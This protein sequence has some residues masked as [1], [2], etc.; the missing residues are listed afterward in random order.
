MKTPQ[1]RCKA[2]IG[3]KRRCVREA[4][5]GEYCNL[6]YNKLKKGTLEIK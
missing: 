1:K 3:L 6:H 5:F 2:T 4:I